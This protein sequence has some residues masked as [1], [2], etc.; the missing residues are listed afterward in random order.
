M[1]S[2]DLGELI[3]LLGRV[4]QELSELKKRIETVDD[5]LDRLLSKHPDVQ[6]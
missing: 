6:A 3:R 5:K 2:G 4:Q 1:A